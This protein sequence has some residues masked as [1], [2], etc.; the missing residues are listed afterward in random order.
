MALHYRVGIMNGANNPRK[1]NW[2]HSS[3]LNDL[4]FPDYSDYNTE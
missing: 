3:N 2:K 1:G 4:P